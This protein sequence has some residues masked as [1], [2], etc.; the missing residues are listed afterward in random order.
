MDSLAKRKSGSAGFADRYIEGETYTHSHGPGGDHE[1]GELAFTTWLDPTL[2]VEQARVEPR[3]AG[4]QH[5]T[6]RGHLGPAV[7]MG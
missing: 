7:G 6:R 4:V 5:W 1:H 3:C 2:A